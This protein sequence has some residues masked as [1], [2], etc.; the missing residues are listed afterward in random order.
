V[1]ETAAAGRGFFFGI[2]AAVEYIEVR[3]AFSEPH[4]GRAMRSL[5]L[6]LLGLILLPVAT[7]AA[8]AVDLSLAVPRGAFT[9]A[10][11]IELA[12]LYKN[13]GGNLAKVPL[14]VKHEDGS[15]LT[16]QVPFDAAAGKGQTRVVTLRAGVLKPGS[17]TARGGDRT[18]SFSVHSAEPITPSGCIR[19]SRARRLWP[20]AAGCT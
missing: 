10:E 16:F 9:T 4:G 8:D 15:S 2:A 20:R 14:E 3:A 18:V 7:T 6:S 13:E 11:A 12:V 5:P 19:A 17:Y 1:L